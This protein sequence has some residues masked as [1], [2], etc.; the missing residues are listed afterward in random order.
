M[1]QTEAPT[2][3][4][5]RKIIH[6]DMDAFYASVEQRDNPDLR[7][8]PVAVGSPRERGVVAAA[9]YEARRFGVHS[10]MASVTAKRKCPD[11][12]FVRP[13]FETYKQV[14]LQIRAIFAEFTTLIEPLSLD[15]AYLDVTENRKDIPF[16]TQVAQ[17][18]RGR[19]FDDTALTASAGVSYNKF[20]AKLASDQRKPNGLFVITPEMGPSFVGSLPVGKFHG[21]G[22]ATAAKMNR[23][24]IHTGA[25][26]KAQSLAFLQERFGKAGSYFYW[27]ALGVDD[28]PVQP[29]L[30]RKSVGA[31][32]TFER[33]LWTF[34]DMSAELQP[35][36]D[37]VW[38]YCEQAG[39]RGR[40]VTLKVKF[41]DFE[42][43]TRRR[44]FDVLVESRAELE[45]ASLDLL[46]ALFPVNKGVRLLGVT[47]S[48]LNKDGERKIEQLSLSLR[49]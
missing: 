6:I 34:E 38:G 49:V 14:S 47:L 3:G 37:K 48:S 40:T 22:P 26:L 39:M 16:A 12:I 20:L 2:T 17:K 13:R 31:E 10:A 24:G 18:I 25:D 45:R 11:L 44:S 43:I 23:L 35:I 1:A 30:I 36:L 7:G 4:R 5:A 41:Q 28:R 19:I 27:I 46:S 15:E 8:R 33:D 42:Q 9:S 32:N 21:I 29:D